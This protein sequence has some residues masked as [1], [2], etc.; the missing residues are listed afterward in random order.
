MS[1]G[2]NHWKL[3]LFVVGGV[4]LTLASL[5]FFGAQS[6]KHE[7][8]QYTFYFDESVQGLEVGA[9]T[10]FRGVTIGN[11]SAIRVAP[12]HR[13]VEV[14]SAMT[15]D[16][17]KRLGIAETKGGIISIHVPP[18]L[19]VQLTSQGVT[20]NKFLSI[21]FFD[22]KAFP[23]PPLSFPPPENYIP[24]A[25]STLRTLEDR[26]VTATERV[27]E[28]M[29]E[30]VRVVDKVNA[31]LE[32]IDAKGLSGEAVATL[33]STHRAA[34]ALER[35]VEGVHAERIADHADKVLANLEVTTRELN[36]LA[37]QING[38]N[39]LMAN[40]NK[41]SVQLGELAKTANGMT[42]EM[43]ETMASI[44]DAAD[45]IQRVADALE[46]DPDM[47]TKGRAKKAAR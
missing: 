1:T 33:R 6:L 11:V 13:Q 9:P 28:L 37:G 23:P 17:L 42:Q 7:S 27:P 31:L 44:R 35:T 40:A 21:D 46:L 45:A 20:G 14:A 15:V 24:T 47:L 3:G 25:P 4:G 36:A 8:V 32:A 5:V 29:Q 30:I 26:I 10:K 41:S 38:Q 2:T 22:P 12:D 16:E 39:G 34:Q 19:R 18:E 43:A